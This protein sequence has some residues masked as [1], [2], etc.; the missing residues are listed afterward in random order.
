MENGRG[1]LEGIQEEGLGRV[2]NPAKYGAHECLFTLLCGL[3]QFS[4]PGG[5]Q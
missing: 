1:S 2:Q 3:Q 4:Q 5:A